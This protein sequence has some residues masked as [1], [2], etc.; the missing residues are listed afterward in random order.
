[1]VKTS[2]HKQEIHKSEHDLWS[3]GTI[4]PGM[5]LSALIAILVS[6]ELLAG[7]G[8]S[9]GKLTR[10]EAKKKLDKWYEVNPLP[11]GNVE[12]LLVGGT[13]SDYCNSPYP[14]SRPVSE[15]ED[16]K[17]FT[18]LGLVT[19]QPEHASVA[20]VSL[21]EAAKKD[22]ISGPY[23]HTVKKNCDTWQ[24]SIPLTEF[25]ENDVTGIQQES[26]NAK[27]EYHS[28]R[29]LTR[30]GKAVRDLHLSDREATL[31]LIIGLEK[32]L[33]KVANRDSYCEYESAHFAKFDDGWR[34]E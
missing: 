29:K 23:G 8:C 16:Y 10:T 21:T 4:L 22:A 3:G 15:Q 31:S 18:R 24:Y 2:L 30:L 25:S 26:T 17:L 9:N 5:K 34:V 32:M 1:V 14:P 28:C 11:F 27:V 13:V 7:V 33:G 12:I 20:T 6:I 19:I